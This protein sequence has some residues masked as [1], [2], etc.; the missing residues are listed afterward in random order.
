MNSK[1][2]FLAL[3]II[4]SMKLISFSAQAQFS[5]NDGN[6]RQ[7]GSMNWKGDKAVLEI[8]TGGKSKAEQLQIEKRVNSIL[9]FKGYTLEDSNRKYALRFNMPPILYDFKEILVFP[10][11]ILPQ[12]K[13][14]YDVLIIEA[15]SNEVHLALKDIDKKNSLKYKAVDF[16]TFQ[17]DKKENVEKTIWRVLNDLP[18]C[19]NIDNARNDGVVFY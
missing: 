8:L 2:S 10:F 16:V 6:F 1:R 3:T 4:L 17:S 11:V 9:Q 19:D 7:C 15:N 13:Y 14:L 18:N 5:E 12:Y